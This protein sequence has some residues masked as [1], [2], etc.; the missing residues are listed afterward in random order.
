MTSI[1]V[2]VFIT[3]WVSMEVK[4]RNKESGDA[5]DEEKEDGSEQKLGVIEESERES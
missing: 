1:L 3:I 5:G 2:A 4:E